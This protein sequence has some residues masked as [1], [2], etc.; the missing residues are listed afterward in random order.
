[1]NRPHILLVEDEPHIASGLIYN[2]EE[3]NY[4]ITHV[5]SGEAALEQLWMESFA[6]IIL[7]IMLPGISGIDVCRAARKQDPKLPILML[8]ARNEDKDRIEGL[9]V[10][11]DDYLTKPF[12]LDEFLLRVKGMLRRSDWYRP[13]LSRERDY[14]FGQNCVNLQD[15]I[16]TVGDTQ[17]ELTDIE[18]KLLRIFF[19]REGEVLS[20]TELLTAAWDVSP[21]TETRTLDNF[22]VRLRKYFEPDPS[23]PI[24]FLTVRGR[25]YRFIRQTTQD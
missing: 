4:Q 13:Q 18:T 24:H 14:C 15:R 23:T 11:A 16:A 5:E 10:G 19:Q 25:G 17:F 3:E 2:L 21:D 7:D 20:R 6:L 12:N 8:T 1:M 9:E 22:V